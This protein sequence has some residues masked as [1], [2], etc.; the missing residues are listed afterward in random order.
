[1]PRDTIDIDT[2]LEEQ[3]VLVEGFNGSHWPPPQVVNINKGTIPITNTSSKPV[4]LTTQKVNS[5]KITPTQTVDWSSPSYSSLSSIST[6]KPP[7]SMPDSETIDTITIGETTTEIR[8]MLLA[9]N[10]R[11][12][13]VFSKDL[14]RSKNSWNISNYSN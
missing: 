9:A 12:R 8:D 1:M 11:F 5:I 13:K 14:S 7:A 10:R 3:T 2:E 6:S 4:I